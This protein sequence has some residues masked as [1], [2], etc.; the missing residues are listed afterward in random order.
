MADRKRYW[1][2]VNNDVEE[3]LEDDLGEFDSLLDA[4]EEAGEF[5]KND[6]P[7]VSPMDFAVHIVDNTTSTTI[8]IAGPGNQ[9]VK[10][11]GWTV[12]DEKVSKD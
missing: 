6:L 3:E 2:Y 4:I 7:I 12:M 10:P 5:I 11:E 9:I 1:V 8:W